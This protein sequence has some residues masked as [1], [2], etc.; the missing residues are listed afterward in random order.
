MACV[1]PSEEKEETGAFT[2]VQ[3]VNEEGAVFTVVENVFA[4]GKLMRFEPAF[5]KEGVGTRLHMRVKL[6]GLTLIH[7]CE[8]RL[9]MRAP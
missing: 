5:V 6:L 3:I 4:V 2:K 8:G 7:D 9:L 1:E